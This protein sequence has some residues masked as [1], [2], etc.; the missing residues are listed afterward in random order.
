MF[1]VGVRLLT[2]Y[3][4]IALHTGG[5]L[6]E[7]LKKSPRAV[8]LLDEVEKAHIDVLTI[9]LQVFDEGRLTDGKGYA[10]AIV[11]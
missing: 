11:P 7:K 1:R 4:L 2:S 9:L 10:V 3:L 6:T 8:V 5:Q